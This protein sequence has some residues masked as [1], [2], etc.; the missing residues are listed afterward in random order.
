MTRA[1]AGLWRFQ[2]G[3]ARALL[4]VESEAAPPREVADLLAQPGFAVYRN[5]VMKGCI[6]ALQCNYPAVARLVGEEWFRAAAAVYVRGNLPRHAALLDYGESFPE[7]LSRFPPAQELPYLSGVARLDRYWSEAHAA[8]DEIPV[9]AGAVARLAPRELASAALKPHASARWAWFADQPAY[10]IWKRNRPE[11]QE[12]DHTEIQWR[13]E[14]ALVLRPR[15]TVQWI[16]LGAAGCA[17][18]AACAAGGRLADAAEAALA[19]D[20][21]ANLAALM[22]QL[23]Q[24][25]AFGQLTL[26]EPPEELP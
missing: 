13:A 20:P 12:S 8:R 18:L 15:D 10:S 1:A 5:T 24:A 4:A 2:D 17:F 6:D 16:A 14:G 9:D 23:L 19:A 22:A 26:H 11:G 3:F 7:F 25:G 21:K